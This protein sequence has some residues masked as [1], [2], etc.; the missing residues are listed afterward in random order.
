M[1]YSIDISQVV[2][3]ITLSGNF[4]HDDLRSLAKDTER[5]E[6]TY[7]AAPHRMTN[8]QLCT[9][10]E[11]T[12]HDVLAFVQER[13]RLRFPNSYKSAIVAKDVAHYGFARMYET[14]N[15]HPQIVIAIFS[16]EAD[17]MKWLEE[18]GLEPYGGR[19]VPPAANLSWSGSA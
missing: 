9:R 16:D 7:A 1:P 17:A 19:W 14:L 12:F 4:T 6:G 11:L 18:P 5:A 8:A 13:L 2:L 3:R 15:D 10:L